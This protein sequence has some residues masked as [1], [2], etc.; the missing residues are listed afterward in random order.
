MSLFF[1]G[2][3]EGS[4][5]AALPTRFQTSTLMV[6][7]WQIMLHSLIG[8]RLSAHDRGGLSHQNYQTNFISGLPF[9]T[10]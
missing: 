3:G 6:A 8:R 9:S 7:N 10:M 2:R 5:N 4:T 1:L